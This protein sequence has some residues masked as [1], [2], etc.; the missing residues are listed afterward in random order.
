MTAGLVGGLAVAASAVLLVVVQAP[1]PAPTGYGIATAGGNDG[2]SE[3]VAICNLPRAPCPDGQLRIAPPFA[4]NSKAAAAFGDFDHSL[5]GHGAYMRL[6]I[7]YDALSSWNGAR[8]RCGPSRYALGPPAPFNALDGVESF[9]RLVWNV[10]GAEALGL[11]PEVV[12]SAGSGEGA[13]AYPDPGYG[14]RG[15]PFAGLTT[16]GLD[17]YCGVLGVLG[18]TGA[19]LGSQAPIRWEAFN[20]PDRYASYLGAAHGLC[21]RTDTVCGVLEAAE[22]WELAQSAAERFGGL[23]IAALS[24]TDPESAYAGEYIR[25]LETPS[26][27]PIAPEPFPIRC[28][29]PRYWAVHDYDDPTAGGTADLQAFEDS[30]SAAAERHD[31]PVYVWVTESGVEPGSD[32]RSDDNRRGCRGSEPDN[33]GTLGACVDGVPQAQERGAR[34]WRRLL[35]VGARG[36][37]TTTV[38]WFEFQLIGSWDSAL[39]DA[40]GRPRPALCALLPG[41]TCDGNSTDYL[42]D[43]TRAR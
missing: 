26:A 9:D 41:L 18:L 29:F 17:Y 22:L 3:A 14:E 42:L 30:L 23:Q 37:R 2:V 34:A 25:Q 6:W 31:P 1:T 43:A 10:Q 35:G 19:E 13:P 20:E 40:H 36:V 24:T 38:D 11:T 8:H 21:G 15:H 4:G 39:V 12:F 33:A 27:C 7:P 32:T 28:Q 5:L 16:G